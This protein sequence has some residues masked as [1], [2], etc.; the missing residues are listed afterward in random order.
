MGLIDQAVD[1]FES[2]V[3]NIKMNLQIEIKGKK[4]FL[5]VTHFYCWGEMGF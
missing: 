1:A 2:E 4:Q 5:K 3:S